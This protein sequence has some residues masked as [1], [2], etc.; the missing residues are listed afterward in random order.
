MILGGFK[1]I[2]EDVGFF[3]VRGTITLIRDFTWVLGIQILVPGITMTG[4]IIY[5]FSFHIRVQTDI[6]FPGR[7]AVFPPKGRC[8]C[9]EASEDGPSTIDTNARPQGVGPTKNPHTQTY[10]VLR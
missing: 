6:V 7:E 3:F 9:A 5:K 8:D 4:N 2:N 1:L 10:Q